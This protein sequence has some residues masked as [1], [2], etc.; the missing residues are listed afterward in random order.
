MIYLLKGKMNKIEESLRLLQDQIE[1]TTDP[2]TRSSLFLKKIELLKLQ[3]SNKINYKD[4]I[5]QLEI[6]I[7]RSLNKNDRKK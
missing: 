7:K 4:V 2:M 6:D 1:S 5:D 3:K